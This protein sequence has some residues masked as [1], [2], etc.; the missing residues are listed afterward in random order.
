MCRIVTNVGIGLST[1]L[2]INRILNFQHTVKPMLLVGQRF[3]AF[4][5]WKWVWEAVVF[6][7]KINRLLFLFSNQSHS[8]VSKQ[9]FVFCHGCIKNIRR[10]NLASHSQVYRIKH[11]F[12]KW[13]V[14]CESWVFN[15]IF[16]HIFQSPENPCF[17][18]YILAFDFFFALIFEGQIVQPPVVKVGFLHIICSSYKFLDRLF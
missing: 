17:L 3:N 4:S 14:R 10:F 7:A 8:L 5:I 11:H 2:Y 1:V 16:T 12:L 15:P 6:G 9:C 18:P 13:F